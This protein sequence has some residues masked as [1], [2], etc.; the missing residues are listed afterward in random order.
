MENP[1]DAHT[2]QKIRKLTVLLPRFSLLTLSYYS[3]DE[4]QQHKSKS[5]RKL[6]GLTMTDRKR[7]LQG[8]AMTDR[9]Y[10]GRGGHGGR[11]GRG[12][13]RRNLPPSQQRSFQQGSIQQIEVK[14]NFFEFVVL[15]MQQEWY[16]YDI[17]ILPAFNR[18]ILGPDGEFMKDED[19]KFIK[20]LEI[21]KDDNGTN[22]FLDL[23]KGSTHLS[24]RI[25]NKLQ[26]DLWSKNPKKY[27]MVS[28]YFS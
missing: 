1:G 26:T 24:C 18:K 20:E 14:T 12:G 22:K 16:M 19:G 5:K 21:K 13:D 10:G 23:S 4:Q 9:G 6:Q 2:F 11:G 17:Q 8:L 25:L 3:W 28:L 7:K 27:F 15:N